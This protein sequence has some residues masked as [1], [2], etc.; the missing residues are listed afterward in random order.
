MPVALLIA[1]IALWLGTA[2]SRTA[3]EFS[4]CQ[5]LQKHTTVCNIAGGCSKSD[6]PEYLLCLTA[7]KSSFAASDVVQ[8]L[9]AL[10]LGARAGAAPTPPK[11]DPNEPAEPVRK[12]ATTILQKL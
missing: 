10:V 8:P 6:N 2:N 7:F 5:A 12:A 9:G 1:V 3:E 11:P 4:R